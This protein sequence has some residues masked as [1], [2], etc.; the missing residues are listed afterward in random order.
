MSR[1]S[2]ISGLF[3]KKPSV[4][5]QPAVETAEDFRK[6]ARQAHEEWL[7]I[8]RFNSETHHKGVV[9]RGNALSKETVYD[10]FR[11]SPAN[12]VIDLSEEEDRLP[13]FA[14]FCAAFYADGNLSV[15]DLFSMSG[16]FSPQNNRDADN[17]KRETG[18][19]VFNLLMTESAANIKQ[20]ALDMGRGLVTFVPRYAIP[21][22]PDT[23][24]IR[25]HYA[26]LKESAAVGKMYLRLVLDP[27][28]DDR[29]NYSRYLKIAKTLADYQSFIK[30][31][32]LLSFGERK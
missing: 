29:K 27:V 24:F 4:S 16:I 1:F 7:F 8:R 20:I 10:M 28:R 11:H 12:S 19:K 23:A 31:V 30:E 22:Y 6:A 25:E 17:I 21:E 3:K 14:L 15:N 5:E 18:N 2:K 32:D 13:F 9:Y 26:V